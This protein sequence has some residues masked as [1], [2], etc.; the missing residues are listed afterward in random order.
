MKKRKWR[1]GLQRGGDEARKILQE[2]GV[3]QNGRELC[4][5]VAARDRREQRDKHDRV[6][7]REDAQD[8]A[9]IEVPEDVALVP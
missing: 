9:H 6:V 1:D 7:E 8:A 5:A 3:K 4:E 2:A